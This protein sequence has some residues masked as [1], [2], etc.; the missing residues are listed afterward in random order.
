MKALAE[1]FFSRCIKAFE[2]RTGLKQS[3]WLREKVGIGEN[4]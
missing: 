4:G 1:N 3:V 2:P